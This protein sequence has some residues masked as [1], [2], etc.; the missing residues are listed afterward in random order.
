M[1]EHDDAKP[2]VR[3][4]VERVLAGLKPFQRR[5]VK[6]VFDRLYG[7][8]PTRRFLLADEVGLGK[9][10]VARGVIARAI[11]HLWEKVGR[12]D[13]VY[14]C[15]NHDIA[16]QNINRLNITGKKD[17][18]LA[19]RITLLPITMGGGRLRNQKL[20]F[21]SFTPGTSFDLK[22][23]LGVST[24]RVLLYHLL[25]GPWKLVGA[26]PRNVL[27]GGCHAYN[28]L[29]QLN[30]FPYE[31]TIDPGMAKLFLEHVAKEPRLRAECSDLCDHYHRSDATVADDV[32]RRRNALVGELR[33]ILARACL[34][35]LEPDLIILDE[36]Q[37]FKHL[38]KDDDESEASQLAHDLFRYSGEHAQARVLML[39]ATP[40]KM[41]TMGHESAVDDH[42]A[43]FMDTV[44]FLLDDD[45][46]A[47]VVENLLKEY[48]RLLYRIGQ[49]ETGEIEQVRGELE[50]SLR[51]V[52]CRT[53]RLAV[54]ADRSGMLREIPST[55][56]LEPGDV[57]SY[58]ALQGVARAL[59]QH[60]T[61]EYWK[62]APFLMSFM[63]EYALKRNLEDRGGEPG[64]VEAFGAAAPHPGVLLPWEALRAF[65]PIDPSNPRMRE[66]LRDTVDCGAWGALWVPPS[67][68]YYN[69]TGPLAGLAARGFTK[70]LVFSSWKVVPKAIATLISYEAERRMVTGHDPQARNTPE[71]RKAVR[72][73]L[74]FASSKGRLTGMPVLGLLYPSLFLA[75]EFD[76]LRYMSEQPAG[77][78]LE[79]AQVVGIVEMGVSKALLP[80]V[81]HAPQVGPEDE[82]WYWAAPILLDQ[83]ADPVS[84]GVWWEDASLAGHWSGAQDEEGEEDENGSDNPS[85]GDSTGGADGDA[86]EA[87]LGWRHHVEHAR[88]VLTD[89]RTL[90]GR[91]PADLAKVVAQLAV[92]GP[93]VT[94]LRA[95][96]RISGGLGQTGDPL[97]RHM[98]G[99]VAFGFRTLFNA[100][101]VIALI[102]GQNGAEPYW[103]RVLEYCLAGCVQAVLDEYVHVLRESLG[104]ANVEPALL[105]ADVGRT[106]AEALDLRIASP[107]ADEITVNAAGTDLVFNNHRLRARF[108]MRFGDEKNAEG[109]TVSRADQVRTAFNSPFWPFV[110]ATTSVGQEGLDFHTYCHAVMHWNLPANP[111]D[112]EQ[113]EGRVH[114]YKG[115]AVR[116]NVARR[117]AGALTHDGCVDPWA[118]LFDMAVAESA[119]ASGL[120]PFW[121]Y[122]ADGGAVIERHVPVLPLSRE[123]DQLPA[124]RNSLAV[125]RMVFG[126]PRQDDLVEFLLR[127]IPRESLN[128]RL[129]QLRIDLAPSG[130]DPC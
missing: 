126:Q 127:Q 69:L 3:P 20:N 83:V 120:T 117:H 62:S 10:L 27:R 4:D 105:V 101:D 15:S 86:R 110:L 121:V 73:L 130:R 52:M 22:S 118:R 33:T 99:K 109:E 104:D 37:R 60:D 39:S 57:A 113:R 56:R 12:I 13:V 115:H 2:V 67:I 85:D 36:F 100:P 68:P 108:A 80:F 129:E 71:A 41:Y 124:L 114:R 55:P 34:H 45:T 66:L 111:V 90:L 94:T 96:T 1:S 106:V 48:R 92:A 107:G 98:A 54:T 63:E 87:G 46:K 70:R 49:D 11:E 29:N 119:D 47:K 30:R 32:T 23:S 74:N 21:V 43:D 82:A 128:S 19:S 24:E 53:E 38:L 9:T 18:A 77:S 5:S 64:V 112:M 89:W 44:R 81:E 25:A 78:R 122:T 17:F 31:Y 79:A 58:V 72:P 42:Y 28:F 35:A 7:D 84:T 75:R 14:I 102:R 103:R 123:A 88:R 26:G 116:R 6:Y 65:A 50:R 59:D 95:I 61:V 51:T 16:R 91:P 76:P 40:Y 93:A 97:R 125:Y 8:N